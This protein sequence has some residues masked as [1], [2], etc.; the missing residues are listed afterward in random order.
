MEKITLCGDNCCKCPRYL[1]KTNGELEKVAEL[2]FRIGWR[3]RIVPIEEIRCTGCTSHKQCT[4]CLVDCVKENHVEKCN[5]CPRFPCEKITDL[6][7]RSEK[8]EEKCKAV[9]T[10]EEYRMLKSAF[11]H[12][13][14]NC[15]NK[16]LGT[17]GCKAARPHVFSIFLRSPSHSPRRRLTTCKSVVRSPTLPGKMT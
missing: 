16:R 2:W 17:S 10:D 15:R 5:Q 7:R 4:Y 3:D 13:E 1:A 11:F 12:K 14:E 9:C 8:Y 6:L